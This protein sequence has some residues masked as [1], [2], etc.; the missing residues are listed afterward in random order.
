MD[1]SDAVPA[2]PPVRVPAQVPGYLRGGWGAADVRTAPYAS[3]HRGGTRTRRRWRDRPGDGARAR[4]TRG[5]IHLV[6]RT[7]DRLSQMKAWDRFSW[8]NIVVVVIGVVHSGENLRRRRSEPR[9]ACGL[10][11]GGPVGKS[12]DL[13][14][15]AMFP[16]G[17]HRREHCCPHDPGRRPHLST[18]GSTAVYNW[19]RSVRPLLPTVCPQGWGSSGGHDDVA[20]IWVCTG[21]WMRTVSGGRRGGERCTSAVHRCGRPSPHLGTTAYGGRY[22]RFS[23]RFDGRSA[24]RPPPRSAWSPA[25]LSWGSGRGSQAPRTHESP[26]RPLPGLS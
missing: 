15:T 24:Q 19:R 3:R 8:K 20:T 18:P 14:T 11:V 5:T 10:P 17:V 12:H 25:R 6:Q 4:G 26:G 2:V 21:V 9:T 1:T 16:T 7:S 13:L 23:G 22:A